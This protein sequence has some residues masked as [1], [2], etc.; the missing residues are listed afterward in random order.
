M[1][2][3]HEPFAVSNVV[4]YTKNKTSTRKQQFVQGYIYF[5]YIGSR[6]ND[7]EASQGLS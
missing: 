6:W 4:C 5:A 3:V 1:C 7:T 2:N